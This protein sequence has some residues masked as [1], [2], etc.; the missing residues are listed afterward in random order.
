MTPITWSGVILIIYSLLSLNWHVAVSQ[1]NYTS[2]QGFCCSQKKRVKFGL[3]TRN[4]IN[5]VV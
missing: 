4:V 2:K 1:N 3:L 5:L